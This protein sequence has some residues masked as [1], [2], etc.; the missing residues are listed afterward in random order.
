M[1]LY[2]YVFKN[3][4]SRK[5]NFIRTM[6]LT[7]G[8]YFFLTGLWPIV[9]IHSFILVTGP[10]TDLWLVKMV[11]LLTMAISFLILLVAYKRRITI[12][13]LTLI[14]F[15]SFSYL[16]IDVIYSLEK[17]IR[18]VYLGDAALQFLFIGGWIQLLISV[19][20]K[21]GKIKHY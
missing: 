6:A 1:F 11:G 2:Y 15:S 19:G 16:L 13:S 14:L 10:K 17:V 20:F 4:P 9:D 12:E 18:Y 21:L 7:Q 5:Q 8:I 3:F